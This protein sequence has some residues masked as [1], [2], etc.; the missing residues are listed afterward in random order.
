MA[1]TK[2]PHCESA[3]EEHRKLQYFQMVNY[4]KIIWDCGAKPKGILGVHVNVRSMLSKHEQ[5]EKLLLDSSLDWLTKTFN[6]ASLAMPGYKYF[7]QDREN[8]LF[9]ASY[10]C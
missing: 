4:S 8:V 1:K 2:E 6:S 7:R 9:M 10:P 3:V 5:L